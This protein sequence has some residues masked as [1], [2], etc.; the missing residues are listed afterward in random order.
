MPDF[1]IG[2]LVGVAIGA[3]ITIIITII[4]SRADRQQ[5][6]AAG[7][8]MREAMRETF[9]ALA[10]D[11]LAANSKHL[12][13][14]TA[15]TLDSKKAL[16]DQAVKAMNERLDKLGLFVQKSENER[17][18][19]FASMNT[20]VASLSLTTGEL[21]K[22]LASPQRRGAWGERMAEDILRTVGLIEGVN[23]KKQS[24]ADAESG[25]PD[26]TFFLPNDLKVNMDVKFP[27][28]A[29]RAYLK[30]E[31]DPDRSA[32]LKALTSS[33]RD[34]VREVA[35]R[36]YV[37]LE[38]GTVNYA[39]VFLASE[40]ILSLALTSQSDL[41]DEALK[42]KI[43]LASPMTLYAML[44]VIRQAAENANIMRTADEVIDLLTAFNKQWQAYC[45]QMDKLEGS[46]TKTATE[47]EK[48]R[49]TRTKALQ[50]PL[51]KIEALRAARELPASED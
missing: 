44:A 2:L 42:A 50:R 22:V 15:A 26:F 46:I 3:A 6:A 29:Y 7:E 39:I 37:D 30:A 33:V 40:Q 13:E 45:E 36:G 27:L 16:I 14:Q 24:A 35:K 18:E 41:I 17:K 12:G 8:A 32:Q 47:F 19:A 28:D 49:T 23:Y 1:I 34:R 20:S 25:R 5:S 21:H 31:N 4:R 9:T 51:D 43:V 11:A 38:G 48:L 10:A